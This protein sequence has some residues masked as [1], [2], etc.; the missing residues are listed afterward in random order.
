MLGSEPGKGWARSAYSNFKANSRA[1]KR[2]A[3]L[4]EGKGDWLRNG[5]AHVENATA[6]RAPGPPG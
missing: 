5:P 6:W 3:F 4:A 1:T 2:L